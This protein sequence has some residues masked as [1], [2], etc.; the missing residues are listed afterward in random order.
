MICPLCRRE[1]TRIRR[2]LGAYCCYLRLLDTGDRV[3][4]VV[5]GEP[6]TRF[7]A[8]IRIGDQAPA[9]A[10]ELGPCWLWTASVDGDGYGQFRVGADVGA[11]FHFA[12]DTVHGTPP[13]G[14]VR[15]HFCHDPETCPGGR[16]CPHRP[17]V[18]PAHI[19]AVPWLVNQTRSC[20]PHAINARKQTCIH[21][22]PLEGENVYRHPKRGTR[23]CRAC[24]ARRES[25]RR[26]PVG[27]GQLALE[28]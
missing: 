12:H 22:H 17:C 10:P 16:T 2:G 18:N 1:T 27:K 13:D 20:S 24:R 19:R 25:Q 26:R 23:D 28:V 4:L 9:H 7:L 3:R 5:H 21:D 15:D 8:H 14:Y 11:A 6:W